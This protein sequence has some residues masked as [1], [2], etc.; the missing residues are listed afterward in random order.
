MKRLVCTALLLALA[1]TSTDDRAAEAAPAS[2][3]KNS[4]MTNGLTWSMTKRGDKL[5]VTYRFENHTGGVVY[6][7]DGLV[8][9]TAT[10][11]F[12]KITTNVQPSKLDATTLLITVGTPSGDVPVAAPVPG[13][14][15]A[16]AKGA[17]FDGARDVMLP[18]QSRD[19]MGR[20]VMLGDTFKQAKLALQVSDGEPAKWREIQTDKGMIKIPD[21][22]NIRIVQSE[23]R[24]LP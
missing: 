6:V 9:Q 10:Q 12:I 23:A 22:P 1:C 18:F 20:V 17:S 13:V 16:V 21:A 15:V 8:A 14:Y 19:A 4:M 5:H 24:A 3:P 11:T 7:N 2:D